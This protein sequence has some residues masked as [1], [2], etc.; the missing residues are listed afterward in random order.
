MRKMLIASAFAL[1]T[2]ISA[3]VFAGSGVEA[4]HGER[5]MQRMTEKL[6]LSAEQQEQ[7]RTIHT[8]QMARHKDIREQTKS[9]MQ[10]VLTDEQEKKLQELHNERRKSMKRKYHEPNGS[11]TGN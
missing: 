7:I 9:R 8:E 4:D 10:E 2:V 11:S 3:P 5:M 6:G 1:T